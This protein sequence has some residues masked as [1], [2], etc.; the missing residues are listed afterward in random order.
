MEIFGKPVRT[1]IVLLIAGILTRCMVFCFLGPD[2]ND[3]HFTIVEFL[4]KY[5]TFPDVRVNPLAFHP[6]LYYWMAAAILDLTGSEKAV[7]FLS[8]VTSIATLVVL[9]RIIYKTQ[10]IVWPRARLYCFW[11]ACFLPQFILFGLYVSNDSLSFFFG[12]LT[13]LQVWNYLESP[14]WKQ[15][16]LLAVVTGLGLLTKTTFLVFLP[17]LSLFIFFVQFRDRRS[18]S[19]ATWAAVFFL[20]ISGVLGSY[21]FIDSYVR[22]KN[23]LINNQDVMD[24]SPQTRSYHG[25]GTYFDFNILRL[26]ATPKIPYLE[27]YVANVNGE[28]GC[29][30]LLLYGSFWYDL[31]PENNFSGDAYR[32][33]SYIGSAIYLVALVPTAVFL[34]GLFKLAGRLPSF[35]RTFDGTKLEDCG[36]MCA[37][38]ASALLFGNLALIVA[39]LVKY[40]AWSI[41]QGRLLFPC[42]AGGLAIFAVGVETLDKAR[43]GS[44]VLRSSMIVLMV[45][46]GL[47]FASE[48][49]Y[50]TLKALDP[51]VKPFMKTLVS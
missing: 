20:T 32:P 45:L 13:V 35:V 39:S 5:K 7:Q 12:C 3:P 48:I 40:H 22:Y 11:L 44:V 30:P 18:L 19:K 51:G 47:Y 33:V 26:V 43:Y 2:N 25:L 36:L 42:L 28:T 31:I 37:Y 21:R 24:W 23:P 41:M 14:G 1:P 29:Y 8:L 27:V 6:P 10:I 9:Y 4:V 49:G 50:V 38:V 16:G 34:V 46:F 17:V 15:G